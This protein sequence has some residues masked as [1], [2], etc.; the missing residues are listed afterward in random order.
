[1]WTR[2]PVWVLSAMT[3]MSDLHLAL[4]LQVGEGLTHGGIININARLTKRVTENVSGEVIRHYWKCTP[5]RIGI[6]FSPI[7]MGDQRHA[8]GTRLCRSRAVSVVLD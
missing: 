2:I 1:M 6:G 8:R 4:S 7:R 5:Y 3:A